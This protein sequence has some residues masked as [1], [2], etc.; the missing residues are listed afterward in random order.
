MTTGK[1]LPESDVEATL[2][3]LR[4]ADPDRKV[5]IIQ[6]F[7]VQ[8]DGVTSLPESTI[9]PFL[10]LLPPLLRTPHSLLLNTVLSTFIPEFL[11]LIPHQPTSHLRIA[12]LQV[13]PALAEKLND[14]K[15]RVHAAAGNDIFVLGE[16]SWKADPPLPTSS[17]GP[18]SGKSALSHGTTSKL[19]SSGPKDKETLSALW[20]R[21][22]K[23][24]L[25]G[26]AK[27]AKVEAMKVLV[28][29]REAVGGKMGLKG[30]LSVLVDLLEDGDGTVRDQARETVVALLAPPTT[31][32]AARSELKKLIVAKN[33]RKNIAD[34][35]IARILGG[36]V[37]SG[38]STPAAKSEVLK[39]DA[40][41]SGAGTP[42]SAQGDDVDI[43]YIASSHDLANEFASIL[44]HFE[45]K[46]TEH[47]W[48]PREAAVKRVR[49][50]IKGQAHVKYQDT[51]VAGL[52]NGLLEGVAKTILSLR[53]TV[54]QA[55]CVLL[56]ELVEGLRTAFDNFVEYLLPVLGKMAGLTKRIIADRSQQIVTAIITHTNVHPRIFIAHI[57][58]GISEKNVQ[59][60][61]YCTNHLRTFLKIHAAHA[62]HQIESTAGL[63]EQLDQTVRKTLADV[64]PGV[65]E[66]GRLAFWGYHAVWPAKGQV[67]IGTLDN[68]AKKSL[69]KVNPR[70]SNLETLSA[71]SSTSA[72]S[73]AAT[74]ATTT[75]AGSGRPAGRS[76]GLAA[77]MAERRK[78]VKAAADKKAQLGESDGFGIS[79]RIVSNPIQ[80]SPNVQAGLPRSNSS[81]LLAS[82]VPQKPTQLVRSV[83]SPEGSP[84]TAKAN[85]GLLAS[86]TPD[87]STSRRLSKSPS[88]SPSPLD[89]QQNP[90]TRATSLGPSSSPGGGV[91]SPPPRESPL[92][93][94]S[95]VPIGR[96]VESGRKGLPE[97]DGDG[98]LGLGLG[99]PVR[100]G[101]SPSSTPAHTPGMP[102]TP[103]RAPSA[104]PRNGSL[105]HTPAPS[106]GHT[107]QTHLFRTPINAASS[108]KA[109]EDSPR[110]EA[111]TPLMMEKLKERKHERSWWIKRQELMD[112]ASPLKPTTPSPASAIVPDLESLSSGNIELRNL[113]KL[114]LFSSSH[115]VRADPEE[116]ED[117]SES[118]RDVI[119]SERK[120]WED[121]SL[122][123]RL[124]DSL[125]MYLRP[126][127][128]K[129]LLEQGLV[130]LWEVVQHQW[131]L[132]D[133]VGKL[134]QTLFRLRASQDAVILE[135]TN[136]L[137]SLLVQI[138]DPM[139]LLLSLCSSLDKFL[140]GHPPASPSA[141]RLSEGQDP[142]TAA[143]SQLSLG[144]EKETPEERIRNSGYLFGLTSVGMCVLRLSAPVV[145]SEGPKLGRIVMAAASNPSSIIRQASQSLL[146]SIQC[147]LRNSN[148]TLS[149][150]PSLSK[151]QKDLAIYYMAQN[152]ILEENALHKQLDNAEG[153]EDIESEDGEKKEEREREMM[154]GEL[155]GLMARGVARE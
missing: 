15:E 101:P 100:G 107:A 153:K 142:L 113:Q 64:N 119:T 60:R 120:L 23:D 72:S 151:G 155:A 30:W 70:D 84:L 93:Q 116:E 31:P 95:T 66:A 44:P 136:A 137:V 143:L 141:P 25:Q 79:P 80:G 108:R 85:P 89:R 149:L 138:S 131:C 20:E 121:D 127:K 82:P 114:A 146:L 134:C 7:T 41:R 32:P 123:E 135:S 2:V 154:N 4:S 94:S 34:N 99:T 126:E 58:S 152:G 61:A 14:A 83:T 19:G 110:P 43:V 130:I 96:S 16:I 3:K 33:V 54:A 18:N 62:K 81:M 17:F 78:A 74:A 26:R 68:Q 115:P 144:P 102:G 148:K 48:G 147:I 75:S 63:G 109:W 59:I 91:K 145:V 27:I 105:A 104:T 6:Y 139:L 55:S 49:G 56:R 46:E 12:L 29:L 87:T 103:A 106:N 40:V 9:D 150:V 90:R 10:L 128:D 65:R 140:A 88:A 1:T 21:Q 24:V 124:L 13:F 71:T 47:N 36:E 117:L 77:M 50:M 73:S 92:R 28:K 39:D 76:S 129:E 57:F 111:V 118:E 53:T 51:F 69:D 97:F 133:D 86:P 35:I 52:K 45:G 112:K 132:V 37:T 11:P 38:R 125:L 42:A 22:M 98:G 67:I 8:L 122:F 5:D